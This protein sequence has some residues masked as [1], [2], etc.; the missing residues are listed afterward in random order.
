MTKAIQLALASKSLS[1]TSLV[2]RSMHLAPTLFKP[3][4]F[5]PPMLE[6]VQKGDLGK[7]NLPNHKIMIP[8][9]V[10]RP[11][12]HDSL[13][14]AI[15]PH[16][17]Q[18]PVERSERQDTPFPTPAP[19]PAPDSRTGGRA[20]GASSGI[21]LAGEGEGEGDSEGKGWRFPPRSFLFPFF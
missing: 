16:A 3:S 2:R 8:S 6:E 9:T 15:G 14:S 5:L 17:T 21:S 4:N 12:R 18:P 1:I 11:K 13:S 19:A 20:A 7:T 10:H